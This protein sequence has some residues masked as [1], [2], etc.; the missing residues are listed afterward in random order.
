M[1]KA[2][3]VVVENDS[4]DVGGT[5]RWRFLVHSEAEAEEVLQGSNYGL[6]ALQSLVALEDSHTGSQPALRII[7]MHALAAGTLA[8]Q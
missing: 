7:E 6:T 1:I 2:L 3:L 5:L 4:G 8:A